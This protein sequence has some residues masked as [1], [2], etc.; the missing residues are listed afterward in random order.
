MSEPFRWY[1][2]VAL[3]EVCSAMIALAMTFGPK[4]VGVQR[5]IPEMLLQDPGPGM[6]L[7]VWFGLTNLMIGILGL[8][9]WLW[10]RFSSTKT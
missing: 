6:Q 4:R 9:L 7:L 5:G 1:H 10:V 3:A 8:G 2:G